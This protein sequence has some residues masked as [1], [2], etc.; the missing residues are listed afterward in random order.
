MQ[1][2]S[3]EHEQNEGEQRDSNLLEHGG[4]GGSGN[5]KESP[6]KGMGESS[7]EAHL[8]Q[9]DSAGKKHPNAQKIQN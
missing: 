7:P 1:D 4:I 3:G 2:E 9:M 6:L 8:K 5:K